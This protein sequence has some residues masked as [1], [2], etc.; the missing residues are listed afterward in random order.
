[1]NPFLNMLNHLTYYKIKD[2]L[3]S[4][5][6]MC[7]VVGFIIITS[8]VNLIPVLLK[9]SL[10]LSI[11]R[12]FQQAQPNHHEAVRTLEKLTLTHWGG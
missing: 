9:A 4:Q 8:G 7:V 11:F 5:F 1:M 10:F 12:S 6:A 2:S 3:F